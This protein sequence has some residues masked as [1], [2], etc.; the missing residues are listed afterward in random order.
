LNDP[1]F[2]RYSMM[3][4]AVAGPMPGSFSRSAGVA[5]FRLNGGG[6]GLRG[7]R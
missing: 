1:S 4:V 6:A 5:V 3:R 7:L 2:S